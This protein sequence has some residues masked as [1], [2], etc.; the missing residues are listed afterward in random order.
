MVIP[1]TGA[2]VGS[3]APVTMQTRMNTA[4]AAGPIRDTNHVF[5]SINTAAAAPAITLAAAKV[6]PTDATEKKYP[7]E[8]AEVEW[9]VTMAAW[10]NT[11]VVKQPWNL[12]LSM[13]TNN[14]RNRV[15]ST[16]AA[17][18]EMYP[19]TYDDWTWVT[20]CTNTQWG[21]DDADTSDT[22]PAAT[23]TNKTPKCT[24]TSTTAAHMLVIPIDQDLTSTD[25]STFK[26]KFKVSVKLPTN[27]IGKTVSVT[28]F[29]MDSANFQ[30][31]GKS[32][33]ITTLT[34]S[35]PSGQADSQATSLVSFGKDPTATT[36]SAKGVGLYS[37]P[38]CLTAAG[39]AANTYIAEYTSNCGVTGSLAATVTA[40]QN[41]A[42]IGSGI[43]LVNSLEVN[44]ALPYG[45]PNDR[46]VAD[47]VC[48]TQQNTLGTANDLN[49]LTNDPMRVHQASMMA[50]GWGTGNCFYLGVEGGSD[51]A[52]GKHRFQCTNVGALAKSANLQLAFQFTLSNV[53]KGFVMG[54]T[55]ATDGLITL[56]STTV[57]CELKINTW[58][59]A[60][61]SSELWYQAKA[62]VNV[63]PSG[64]GAYSSFFALE[65]QKP[66]IG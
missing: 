33:A 42:T 2:V 53:G 7:G 32:A 17:L 48:D 40:A 56:V 16:T 43:E 46:T 5:D 65:A 4:T 18:W 50:Q 3:W 15:Q 57:G 58:T 29:V 47:I 49:R 27:L 35:K 34:V 26:I 59:S 12:V 44:W 36:E 30:T 41:P 20:T 13:A 37:S 60:T 62:T 51:A 28:A 22:T 23:L 11:V 64:T 9:T 63:D 52:R 54:G 66:M 55:A 19:V 24:V 6:T 45:I 61:A 1:G 31:F 14:A 25:Y 38:F 21:I 39:T 10:A 8:T